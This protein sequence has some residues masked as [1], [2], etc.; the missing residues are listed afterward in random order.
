MSPTTYAEM[1]IP[2]L[3]ALTYDAESEPITTAPVST[4]HRSRATRA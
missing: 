2:R 1:A 3:P 4:F